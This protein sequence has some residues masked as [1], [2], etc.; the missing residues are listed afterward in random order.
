[1]HYPT[2]EPTSTEAFATVLEELRG[3]TMEILLGADALQTAAFDAYNKMQITRLE[4]P[5]GAFERALGLGS[6]AA[7]LC[8]KM[9][10]FS[11]ENDGRWYSSK[12]GDAG[13]MSVSDSF[14]SDRIKEISETF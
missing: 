10:G 9:A 2:I 8:A 1:M 14:V 3:L 6:D 4:L 11:Q 5:I 13:L 7:V 12:T